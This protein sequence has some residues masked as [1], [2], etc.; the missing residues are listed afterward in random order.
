[1]ESE[2][3]PLFVFLQGAVNPQSCIFCCRVIF[4]IIRQQHYQ[5]NHLKQLS[6]WFSDKMQYITLGSLCHPVM[7]DT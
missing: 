3:F 4:I 7:N 6:V 1:M 5:A 2:A